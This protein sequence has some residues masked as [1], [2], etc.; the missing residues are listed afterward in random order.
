MDP[1][2]QLELSNF[3]IMPSN[4]FLI[5]SLFNANVLLS[6]R[7]SFPSFMSHEIIT[8][9]NMVNINY[10]NSLLDTCLVPTQRKNV[11]IIYTDYL[12][13]VIKKVYIRITLSFNIKN[14]YIRNLDR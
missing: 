11:T 14:V 4:C 12:S 9:F 2:N 8:R 10:I 7:F 13:E 6:A 1:L 3:A 5:M